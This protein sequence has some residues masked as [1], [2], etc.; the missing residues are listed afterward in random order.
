MLSRVN[1]NAAK[2]R[3]CQ[4]HA[5]PIFVIL[6]QDEHEAKLPCLPSPHNIFIM[7]LLESF[8]RFALPVMVI[9]NLVIFAFIGPNNNLVGNN[10]ASTQSVRVVEAQNTMKRGPPSHDE[11]LSQDAYATLS[12]AEKKLFSYLSDSAAGR[13]R[14]RDLLIREFVSETALD[15]NTEELLESA[16]GAMK[17]IETDNEPIQVE[18]F[19]FLFVGSVGTYGMVL[20]FS[21]SSASFI[22]GLKISLLI[23]NFDHIKARQ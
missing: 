11:L 16:V 4:K 6:Q 5:G 3:A 7:R 17:L 21:F 23:L 14:V 19:P 13:D 2:Q 22:H 12:D 9:C 20:G 1:M 15:P 8:R 10:I 18:G